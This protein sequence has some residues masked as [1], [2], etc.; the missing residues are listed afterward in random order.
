MTE[1]S[2]SHDVNRRQ[3]KKK[4]NKHNIDDPNKTVLTQQLL[5]KQ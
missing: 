1:V 3:K 4:V 2:Q 5:G